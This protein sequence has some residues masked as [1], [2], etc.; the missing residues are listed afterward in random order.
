MCETY[1][2]ADA[3][4]LCG[5]NSWWVRLLDKSHVALA[6]STSPLIRS[7]RESENLLP[8]L[9]NG[10]QSNTQ[11]RTQTHKLWTVADSVFTSK[12]SAASM[13]TRISPRQR[14]RCLFVSYRKFQSF[15]V[16]KIESCSG[17]LSLNTQCSSFTWMLEQLRMLLATSEW[18]KSSSFGHFS[19]LFLVCL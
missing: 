11:R 2:A 13:W 1:A 18:V 9:M 19:H 4:Q 3:Q 17:V 6:C 10:R 7:R 16:P 5:G 8:P 12:R 14:L 15:P